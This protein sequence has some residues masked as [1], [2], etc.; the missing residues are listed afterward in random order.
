[1]PWKPAARLHHARATSAQLHGPTLRVI[2][3]CIRAQQTSVARIAQQ[4]AQIQ[5][6]LGGRFAPCAQRHGAVAAH[7]RVECAFRGYIAAGARVV[8]DFHAFDHARI[9]GAGFYRDG[10]LSRRRQPVGRRELRTDARSKTQAFEPRHREDDRR[11]VAAVEFRR[12][13]G[14][15]QVSGV[16]SGT[17]LKCCV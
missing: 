13:R 3:P 17:V 2:A 14:M 6:S 10:G 15:Y 16:I 7:R 5:G 8:E 4:S 1:M 9:A 12:T 11:V